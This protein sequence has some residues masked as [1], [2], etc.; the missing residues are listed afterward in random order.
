ME[1]SVNF[2]EDDDDDDDDLCW[3]LTAVPLK[4]WIFS[5]NC[6]HLGQVTI[7]RPLNAGHVG[8]CL[9]DSRCPL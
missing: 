1:W 7:P 6:P 5:S 3:H 8:G 9:R 4:G 2:V